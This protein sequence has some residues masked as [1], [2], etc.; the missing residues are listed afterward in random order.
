MDEGALVDDALNDHQAFR[1]LVERYYSVMMA[2]ATSI[3]G[4]SLAEEVVQ[5]AWI[6]AYRNL[7]KFEHRSSLKT[8]LI[9]IVSNEAK[10]RL[11]KESKTISISELTQDGSDEFFS[12]YGSDGHW[13]KPP[14]NWHYDTP[15]ALLSNQQFL[16]C[17]NKY[18]AKLSVQARAALTL[19]D[20]HGISLD[21][22]CNILD[23]TA[24]NV[25]VLIHRSRHKV[26]EH[27]ENFQETGTC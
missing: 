19:K 6:S 9:S 21:E 20:M 18:M 2:V 3:I 7:A 24:S 15:D 1:V 14:S 10:S 22:I 17:L 13:S 5:E 23:V 11:R 12:R 25:R 27:I 8:W 16:K 4:D 26:F